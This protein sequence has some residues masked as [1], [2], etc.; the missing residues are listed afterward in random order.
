MVPL[1]AAAAAAPRAAQAEAAE[2]EV[3]ADLVAHQRAHGGHGILAHGG[4]AAVGRGRRVPGSGRALQHVERAALLRLLPRGHAGHPGRG[5]GRGLG[6][7]R[8]RRR[9]RLHRRL[10][11]RGAAA[12]SL[13]A[14]AVVGAPRL[15]LAHLAAALLVV[16]G[17]I[18]RGLRFASQPRL[19]GLDRGGRRLR[20][21]AAQRAARDGERPER[22]GQR[23]LG[24]LGGDAAAPSHLEQRLIEDHARQRAHARELVAARHVVAGERRDEPVARAELDHLLAPSALEQE[25]AQALGGPAQAQVRGGLG[26]VRLDG[27]L[28]ALDHALADLHRHENARGELAA[29]APD[30]R[31]DV[32]E[33][34]VHRPPREGVLDAVAEIDDHLVRDG[35]L[36]VREHAHGRVGRLR[37]LLDAQREPAAARERLEQLEVRVAAGADR[38]E[39]DRMRQPREAL[40]Q[41]VR[42]QL[43]DRRR[44]VAHVDDGVRPLRIE[45]RGRVGQ[46]L[47][48]IG[49]AA[50]GH[51]RQPVEQALDVLGGGLGERGLALHH[52]ADGQ[53]ARDDR[54][55]VARVEVRGD[56]LDHAAAELE[57]AAVGGRRDVRDDHH[58]ER[59][60]VRLP[61]QLRRQDERQVEEVALV[62]L[63][64]HGGRVGRAGR[65]FVL[66][67]PGALRVLL[68]ADQLH[69]EVRA[70]REVAAADAHRALLDLRAHAGAHALG[71]RLGHVRADR[72]LLDVRSARAAAHGVAVHARRAGGG[73]VQPL[74]VADHDAA[75]LA[76][77]DRVDARAVA[78]GRVP[79]EERGV[80]RGAAVDLLLVGLPRLR[81]LA[82]VAVDQAIVSV[83]REALE[84]RALG[85]ADSVEAL[86]GLAGRVE[87][88]L[89]D[90]GH[91][92]VALDAHAHVEPADDQRPAGEAD[93]VRDARLQRA[94]ARGA[95]AVAR[96]RPGQAARPV[97]PEGGRVHLGAR[98]AEHEL[99]ARRGDAALVAARPAHLAAHHVGAQRLAPRSP[100]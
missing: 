5:G 73:R 77:I 11:G 1:A 84:H 40:E 70:R 63:V 62:R 8:R 57:V 92:E 16:G 75:G 7:R 64:R 42:A 14:E 99:F 93:L 17:P 24:D 4:V 36:G 45:E 82:H 50:R 68:A 88:E 31:E 43:A 52:R 96:A 27:D 98:G 38:V 60:G 15:G 51:A 19:A 34:R 3:V 10:G 26:L 69:P 41:P 59:V 76:R 30:H 49:R 18:H 9:A 65:R 47:P 85:D 78:P 89:I 100:G 56:R 2:A 79:L 86:D 58:V 61:G 53:V 13:D 87:E 80:L 74:R 91:R 21:P 95:G 81:A 97:V 54:H 28:V 32:A 39:A 23:A 12:R 33:H 46:R 35:P 22:D 94:D 29:H 48:E 6:L 67:D 90:L 83:H 44:A 25:L 71:A 66:R 55:A 72:E 37:A 20:V